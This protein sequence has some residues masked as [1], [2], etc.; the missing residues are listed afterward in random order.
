MNLNKIIAALRAELSALSE[1]IV[2]LER[3]AR[4]RG[5]RLGRPPLILLDGG[6]STARAKRAPFSAATRR[7]MAAAQKRRWAAVRKQRQPRKTPGR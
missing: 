2:V 6:N 3:L 1:V 4:T 5:R 7:K